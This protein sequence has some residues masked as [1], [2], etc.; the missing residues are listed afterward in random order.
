MCIRDRYID[1]K[2]QLPRSVVITIDDGWRSK[3]GIEILNEYK[4][5]GTLFLITGDYYPKDYE[6]EYVELHSHTDKLHVGGKCPGGQ[7]G[8]IKCLP[9]DEILN[10]LK[11]SRE[12]LNGS[13]VLCYPF[14]EYNN[15]SIEIAKEAGFTM[16][17]AGE[18]SNSNNLTKVG[19]NKF[20]LPRFVVVTYTTMNDFIRYIG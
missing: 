7:G 16:A 1:G 13:T 11:T 5:N 14:Y 17:F 20:K 8:G 19:S 12:K 6:S 10:D 3:L 4:L 2:I 15:Y 18:S 9:R